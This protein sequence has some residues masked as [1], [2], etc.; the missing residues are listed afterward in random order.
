MA[1][2]CVVVA[3]LRGRDVALEVADA[4]VT[5][6]FLEVGAAPLARVCA[7]GVIG[8]SAS[9]AHQERIK[10]NGGHFRAPPFLFLLML[11]LRYFSIF[12]I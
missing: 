6:E 4:V 12:S 3:L 9:R 2:G 7:R 1:P 8:K 5:V 11:S 10:K